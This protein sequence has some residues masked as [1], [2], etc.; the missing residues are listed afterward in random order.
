MAY[1]IRNMHKKVYSTW[2]LLLLMGGNHEKVATRTR[3]R[4][5]ER[6]SWSE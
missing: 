5:R 6:G 3:E 4:E 1:N 2:G